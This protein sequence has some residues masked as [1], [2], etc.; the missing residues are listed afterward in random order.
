MNRKKSHDAV[1]HKRPRNE[2]IRSISGDRFVAAN[3]GNS[4]CV[5][6]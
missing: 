4:G 2:T 1:G 6:S 5:S 3:D